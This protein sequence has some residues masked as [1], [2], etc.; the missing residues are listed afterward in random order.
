MYEFLKQI[1]YV[2]CVCYYL[3][4]AI[5]NYIKAKKNINITSLKTSVLPTKKLLEVA[6]VNTV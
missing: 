2:F 1:K 3:N 5:S 4:C 6:K